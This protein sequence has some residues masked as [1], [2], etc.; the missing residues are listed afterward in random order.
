VLDGRADRREEQPRADIAEAR[1]YGGRIEFA[2]E[3]E[4]NLVNELNGGGQGGRLTTV[5]KGYMAAEESRTKSDRVG[6]KVTAS[7]ASGTLWGRPPWGYLVVGNKYAKG[8]VPTDECLEVAPAMFAMIR[9]G[10]SLREV[11]EC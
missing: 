8:M 4:L 9:D 3:P 11:A 1:R 10:S 7:K 6:I 5:V 2:T